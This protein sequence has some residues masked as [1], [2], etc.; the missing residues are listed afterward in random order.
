MDPLH[1]DRRLVWWLSLAQL[2][3]WG[4]VF[5]TFSLLMEPV[6]RELGLGR[7]ASSLAFSLALLAEGLMGWPVGRWIDRGHERAVMCGGTL[8]VAV[9]L[10]LH[11][12]IQGAA[13]FYA[14]WT[15]MGVGLAG[16]LYAPAFAVLTRR[17]P[18]DFRRAI[19]TLT[20]LGGLAST[21]FIPLSAWLIEAVGWRHTLW[22]LAV[23]QL[24]VCLPIHALQLRGAPAAGA[25][26]ATD[27]AQ[28]DAGV[29]RHLRQAPL[30]LIGAF[31]VLMMCVTTALPPHMVALLREQGLPATWV[32]GVPA[33]LGVLQ[34][35]GRVLLYVGDQRL[36]VHR[37]NRWIPALI[38]LGLLALLLGWGVLASA[39]LFAALY[40]M[41]NGMLTIVKG[42]AVAQYVSHAH[43]ATLNGLMALPV[44]LAR[45][46]AP[47][48]LGS[49]WSPAGGYRPGLWLLLG[50]SV[51]AVAAL[52][53]AQHLAL[54]G[55][56][57]P[58][59]TPPSAAPVAQQRGGT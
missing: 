55:A 46:S 38:P 48:L 4:G 21:V 8:L 16:T 39:L 44:A 34:V 23:L 53:V 14:V 7:S 36:D 31:V 17:Y 24:A 49:L 51:L 11:S 2:I 13:G 6:E 52:A 54:R 45:A 27:A 26:H 10:A 18:H 28:R 58:S 9:C 42:T 37:T 56:P 12:R 35:G 3:T 15:F 30:W 57:R 5:Y 50:L 59:C 25:D 43:A 33:L 47:L 20:F 22:V 40:G 41:G 32:I 1:P 29:V 19:I